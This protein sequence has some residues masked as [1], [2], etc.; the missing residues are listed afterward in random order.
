MIIESGYPSL[1]DQKLT[2]GQKTQISI[3]KSCIQVL[4]SEG[5]ANFT[6]EKIAKKLKTTRS[7]IAYYF[8][9]QESLLAFMY[10]L[11]IHQAQKITEERTEVEIN[12]KKLPE[13]EVI[14]IIK[15][16]A[17]W[18]NENPHSMKCFFSLI[19]LAGRSN[20]FKEINHQIRTDGLLNLANAIQKYSPNKS[21]KEILTTARHLQ[22]L[23]LGELVNYF[24]MKTD[25][26]FEEL[27]SDLEHSTLT[28]LRNL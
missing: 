28:F 24:T 2:K 1:F 26:T 7:H 3:A 9:D 20:D 14:G 22:S 21:K 23:L 11:L 16:A 4:A 19:E 27:V 10:K 18:M 17:Y 5:L 15:G 8:P 13:S 6:F 25:L 12:K